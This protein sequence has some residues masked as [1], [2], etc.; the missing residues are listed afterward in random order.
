MGDFIKDTYYPWHGAINRHTETLRGKDWP[1]F[2]YDGKA[3]ASEAE[4][5]PKLFAAEREGKLAKTFRPCAC[6]SEGKHVVDNHLTCCLGVECRKCPHLLALE[7]AEGM[8][9]EQIDQMK[10]WT[11]IAH[12]LGSGGDTM[13]E[14]FILTVDDRMFWARVCGSLASSPPDVTEQ[15]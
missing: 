7:K 10:A 9:P 13:N 11:C 1:R 6:C 5:L 2:M 8:T 12:I 3:A 15:P 4:R 14:G